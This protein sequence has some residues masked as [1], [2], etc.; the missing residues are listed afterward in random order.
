MK[1]SHYSSLAREGVNT[2]GANG[3]FF[4]D[5]ELVRGSLF[6]GNRPEDGDD[7]SVEQV[8]QSIES[9][10]IYPLLRGKDVKK[11]VA[12]PSNFVLIPHDASNPTSPTPLDE[13]PHKTQEFLTRFQSKLST[14]KKFRNFDP[15]QEHWHG[16]YSVLEAT[17]SPYKVVWREMASGAVAA[18]ASNSELPTGV[19]KTIVPDHKLFIIPCSSQTEARFI[20]GIFNSSIA[21]YLI[22]S[23]AIATGISTHVLD[24][25]PIPRFQSS[26]KTHV[27][28]SDVARRC[29]QEARAGKRIT[30]QS[31]LD[32]L[33]A[34]ALGVTKKDLQAIHSALRDLSG[35]RSQEAQQD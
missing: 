22:R 30:G 10:Y 9:D 8:Q 1:R 33:A 31:E 5:A 2:R 7:H 35:S 3:V 17:F 12:Q 28:I 24:R 4:L 15:S 6:I 23:Y 32:A 18:T 21:D 20:C 19:K 16:L 14:R 27:N 29:E 25:L 11:W 13:M 26:N 34:E